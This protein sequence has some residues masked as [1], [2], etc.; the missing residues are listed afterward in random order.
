[1]TNDH[2]RESQCDAQTTVVYSLCSKLEEVLFQIEVRGG[3]HS[4][5]REWAEV[6]E[7]ATLRAN[8]VKY[9]KFVN[10]NNCS[11]FEIGYIMSSRLVLNSLAL[12]ILLPQLPDQLGLQA[13]TVT[14]SHHNTLTQYFLK[15]KGKVICGRKG[16]I[17]KLKLCLNALEANVTLQ[18]F[19]S[20]P[21]SV[22]HS[23]S[24]FF[25][26]STVC[27]ESSES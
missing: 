6:T 9:S 21:A 7:A 27:A 16:K 18:V 22:R 25:L 2:Y 8:F 4:P 19:S 13:C 20:A 12:M 15:P 11:Y 26:S 23:R 24:S 14:L 5:Q 10:F 17:T 3:S 1:M